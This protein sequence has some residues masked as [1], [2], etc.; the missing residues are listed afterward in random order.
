LR[1]ARSRVE[2][3]WG[4]NTEA[5]FKESNE[6]EKALAAYVLY[7]IRTQGLVNDTELIIEFFEDINICTRAKLCDE[8]TAIRFFGKRSFDFFGLNF[9]YIAEQRHR[10]KDNSFGCGVESFK[11]S[12][13]TGKSIDQF[14]CTYSLV[15]N[16][17]LNTDAPEA[18]R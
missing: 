5:V 1:E 2:S 3:F 16:K 9:P 8:A 7:S 11:K 10:T 15:P 18:G 13:R 12:Y 17:A 4:A 6:S 14:S